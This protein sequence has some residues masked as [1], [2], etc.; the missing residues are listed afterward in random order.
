MGIAKKE[1]NQFINLANPDKNG[2]S[3][4][5]DVTTLTGNDKNLNVNNGCNYAK[6]NSQLQEEYHLIKVYEKGTIDT[7][8]N[9]QKNAGIGL[10]KLKTIQLNGKK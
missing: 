1:S 8:I 5:I 3:Q 4:P 2:Y 9:T 6:Q 7:K 10:G